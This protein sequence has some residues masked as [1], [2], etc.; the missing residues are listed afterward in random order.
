MHR[1]LKNLTLFFYQ[2]VMR[3]T[4]EFIAAL[5]TTSKCPAVIGQR[6]V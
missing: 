6:V 2:T 4:T 5:W 1:V 3:H